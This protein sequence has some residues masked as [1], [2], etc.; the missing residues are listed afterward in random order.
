[1]ER[2]ILIEEL[3]YLIRPKRDGF[4]EDMTP[5]ESEIM[6]NHFDYQSNYELRAT[7]LSGVTLQGQ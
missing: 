3:V 5:E 6:G 7:G 4:V 2:D 1:M